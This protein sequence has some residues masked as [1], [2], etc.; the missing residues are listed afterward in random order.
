MGIDKFKLEE[1]VSSPSNLINYLKS[2]RGYTPNCLLNQQQI[3]YILFKCKWLSPQTIVIHGSYVHGIRYSNQSPQDIDLII[4]TIK[5][6]FW[7]KE[8]LLKETKKRLDYQDIKFDITL[9]SLFEFINI[10]EHNT[11]LGQSLLQGFSI[12][13][14]GC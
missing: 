3:D 11:S 5:S 1:I 2:K 14:P 4:I 9:T 6:V 13:Y 12:L 7:E 8:Y 10:M